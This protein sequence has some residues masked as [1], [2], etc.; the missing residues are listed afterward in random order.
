[1]KIYVFPQVAQVKRNTY[2]EDTVVVYLG[3]NFIDV[4][5]TI[6]QVEFITEFGMEGKFK[7]HTGRVARV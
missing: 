3:N 4:P 7:C 1:M 2:L 5:E 6:M